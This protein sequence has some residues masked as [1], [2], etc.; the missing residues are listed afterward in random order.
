MKK[1][2]GLLAVVL[3]SGAALA[4]GNVDWAYPVTPK[5]EPL[6]SVRQHQVPG[7]ARKY[8]QAQ[9]DD[10][11]NPPDWFPGEHPPM[12]EIVAHGGP[13]P[14][15]R[16]CAQCHLPSGDGHPESASLAGLPAAY[17][18]RQMA[19]FKNGERK[20]VRAG[21]MVAMAKVLSDAEVKAAANYFAALKPTAGF[22]KTREADKV[23]ASYV[24]A[25]GMR[26]ALSD[27]VYEPVGSRI[28]VL[29][30]NAERAALRDPKSGFTDFVAKGSL[31]KGAALMA[32]GDD[33]TTACTI[34]H[35]PAL[36]GLGEVPGITGRPATYTFRQLNDMKTGNR[37]GGWVELM[38]PV[39]ANLTPDDMIAL[40]AFLGSRDP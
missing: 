38:K 6:D 11:F 18:V 36:K 12:P 33:K 25:G 1:L 19:A 37:T 32:G 35:G 28:I 7:S 39:V 5:P 3:W 9:I 24:G 15:G 8:T 27:G 31:A 26:F 30:D 29:P 22:H 20:G 34:C 40:A 16:A 10:P 14:A 23:P 17:I 21:N 2:A 4:Q 13:K